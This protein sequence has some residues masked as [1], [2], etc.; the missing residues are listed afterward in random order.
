MFPGLNEPYYSASEYSQLS[1]YPDILNDI[2]GARKA[3][4]TADAWRTLIYVLLGSALVWLMARKMLKPVVAVAVMAVLC[5]VDMYGVNK[6]YLNDDM[7]VLPEDINSVFQKSAADEQ[8][9]Q[10]K[11][12]DYRVLNFTTN[13]FNENETS[14]FHKSIGG[15]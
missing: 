8:I 11:S 3:I 15:S 12:L 6:R 4:F 5:L 14:Y 7:F 1:Q 9:L 2:I 13:T 10:D